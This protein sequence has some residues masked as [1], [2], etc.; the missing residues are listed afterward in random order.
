MIG[1]M[2]GLLLA[3]QALQAQSA[4]DQASHDALFF[5]A[6]RARMTNDDAQADSLLRLFVAKRPGVSAAWYEL[7]R[8]SLRQNKTE[9]ANMYI[10]KA[11]ELDGTNKYYREQYAYI[12]ALKNQFAE[13]AGVMAALADGEQHNQEYLL[14]AALFYERAG[15]FQDALQYL[16]KLARTTSRNEE[17]LLQKKQVYLKMN[18]VP[19]AVGVMETLIAR[20]PRE[21]GHY[22]TLAQIYENN[23]Q[24]DKAAEIYR[25]AQQLFPDDPGVQLGL[26][27]HFRKRNDEAGYE[28]YVRKAIINKSLDADDQMNL[29]LPYMQESEGDTNRLKQG[30]ALAAQLAAQHPENGK[31]L[32]FYADLLRINNQYDEAIAQYKKSLILDPSRYSVWDM[33]LR[34]LT[35]PGYADSLIVYSEKAARLF[36][37]QATVH[38][39]NG[40]GYLNKGENTR[41]IKSINRAIDLQPDEQSPE[42]ADMHA[43]LGDLYNNLK[44]FVR[45]D[46]SFERSLRLNP[47]NPTVLNNYAYYLSVRNERLDQAERM[48][49]RSL[50][51]APSQPTFLDTYGWILYRQ[52]KYDQALEYIR[53]AI[54]ANPAAADA[55]L[56]EHL[57]D[58]YYRLGKTEQAVEN[59]KKARELKGEGPFLNKKIQDRK[60]YE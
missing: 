11:L 38:Y 42:L 58:V 28:E 56:W 10:R 50:E 13:A 54:D 33:L 53:K 19:G 1:L 26:A 12:L 15:R 57:G 22:V 60:L 55:T 23:N 52:K 24:P 40:I 44:E 8:I 37:N 45:S 31:V 36:P 59:W 51:L 3:P 41:A 48:S 5:D 27:A 29:L 25:N 21:P 32:A 35:L 17:I 46:S 7:A 20:S 16:D 4:A 49:R 6:M 14:R 2:L 47:A 18:D 34:T 43:T 39:L 30:Q 9:Q